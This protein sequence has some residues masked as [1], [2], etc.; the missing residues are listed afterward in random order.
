MKKYY[1][2][3]DVDGTL[4]KIKSMFSF[5]E[6]YYKKQNKAFG[7]LRFQHYMFWTKIYEFLKVERTHLNKRY[8]KQ[9]KGCRVE[10][11]DQLGSEWFKVH[12]NSDLLIHN[13]VKEVQEHKSSGAEVVMVS[14]SFVPCLKPI[15]DTLGVK[16][17]LATELH[18]KSG[19]YTGEIKAPQTIG[20]G[21]ALRIQAFLEK[22]K[23]AS[24]ADCFAYGDHESD[25]P[26]LESVGHAC[27]VAGDPVLEKEARLKNWKII[28]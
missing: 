19:E 1:V 12:F 18:H 2:F 11:I 15:A 22:N 5:L 23:G 9:F 7:A 28:N 10:D 13:V 16:H 6:F 25:L 8:Y 14:G 27:V 20:Q 17:I 24:S 26:M 3:V 4:I 21:K